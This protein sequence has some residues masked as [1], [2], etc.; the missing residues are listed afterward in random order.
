MFS[1]R[2]PVLG[3]VAP[4]WKWE[5]LAPGCAVGLGADL[6]AGS[7]RGRLLPTSAFHRWVFTFWLESYT[8][9][10]QAF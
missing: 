1:A 9:A 5:P 2:P 10:A 7:D 6:A 4:C 8:D 3:A